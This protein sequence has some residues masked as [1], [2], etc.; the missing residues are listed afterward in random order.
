MLEDGGEGDI[1]FEDIVDDD[2]EFD[3]FVLEWGNVVFVSVIDGCVFCIDWFVDLFVVKFGVNVVI[4][5][6]V[7]WGDYYYNFK[8]KKIV[9]KKVVGGKL[10]LMF[11]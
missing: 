10:K 7:L 6:K 2:D 11:V 5:K 9:G 1:E 3:V 4:L 8:I